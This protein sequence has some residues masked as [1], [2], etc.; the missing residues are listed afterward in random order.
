MDTHCSHATVS[1]VSV[2]VS[3]STADPAKPLSIVL[4]CFATLDGFCSNNGLIKTM[5]AFH[6]SLC[7]CLHSTCILAFAPNFIKLASLPIAI[8]YFWTL[9][10]DA[11]PA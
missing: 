3:C 10:H 1:I 6:R 5:Q 4:T 9:S 2:L 8:H 7:P 11:C